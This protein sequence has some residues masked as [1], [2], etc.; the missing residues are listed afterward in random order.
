MSGKID[1]ASRLAPIRRSL[2]YV[3]LLRFFAYVRMLD[4]VELR[5]NF[6]K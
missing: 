6:F 4:I 1:E 2:K 5:Q 3:F